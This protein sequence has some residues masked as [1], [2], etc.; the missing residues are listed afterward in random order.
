[1]P[2]TTASLRTIQVY[3]FDYRDGLD[4]SYSY[5]AKSSAARNICLFGGVRSRWW[6]S[7]GCIAVICPIASII[8]S[9]NRELKIEAVSILI[10][11]DGRRDSRPRCNNRRH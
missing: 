5:C 1:M 6:F 8:Q 10:S 7:E 11:K 2:Q 3:S 9:Q 4:R